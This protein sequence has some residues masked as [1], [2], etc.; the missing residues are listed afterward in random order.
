VFTYS[1]RRGTAAFDLG[2]PVSREEKKR[3]ARDLATLGARLAEEFAELHVGTVVECLVDRIVACGAAEGVTETYLRASTP[4][5]GAA[6]PGRLV[7]LEITKR[8]R[9]RLM[10]TP[11]P[12][13]RQV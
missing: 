13:P 2:D 5:V 3:R 6:E 8:D 4:Y 1:P 11:V 12:A 7:S 10:G 9:D